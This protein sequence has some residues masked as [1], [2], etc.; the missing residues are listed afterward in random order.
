MNIKTSIILGIV[1]LSLVS[2]CHGQES[3]ASLIGRVADQSGGAVPGAKVQ[4]TNLATGTNSSSVTNS[5]GS[6][7]IPY[8]LP[9]VYRVAVEKTGFKT[10]VMNSVELRVS[11]RLS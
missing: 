11:D 8:L 9:G 7:E 1:W 6:Y 10:S 5:E 3:R 4:A 2:L